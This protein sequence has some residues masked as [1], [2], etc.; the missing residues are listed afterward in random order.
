M[1]RATSHLRT[2]GH[3]RN[4][5]VLLVCL[6]GVVVI[7]GCGG[8]GGGGEPLSKEDYE[9]QMQAL[10]TDLSA[11]AAEL[12]RAFSDPQDI[13]AMA[14]GLNDAADLLD[15]ASQSLDEISPPEDVADAHQVMVD[16]SASAAERL[17][18]FADSVANSSV[19]DLQESL[20]E[21]QNFEEFQELD[22]AV[23]EIQEKGYNIGGS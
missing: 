2:G 6:L 19:A 10:Q 18:E 5:A 16:K 1:L 14:A 15:E 17:R 11:S 7:A 8:G 21:F 9:A 23:K 12:Q 20:T 3:V 4:A 13:E 22:T